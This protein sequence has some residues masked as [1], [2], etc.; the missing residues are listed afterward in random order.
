[1]LASKCSLRTKEDTRNAATT[2]L[3]FPATRPAPHPRKCA[4]LWPCD[5]PK[6]RHPQHEALSTDDL[7]PYANSTKPLLQRAGSLMRRSRTCPAP[8]DCSH[9]KVT[10]KGARGR[11]GPPGRAHYDL[12]SL[13]SVQASNPQLHVAPKREQHIIHA[14]FLAAP[15]HITPPHSIST[16]LLA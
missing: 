6:P 2:D 12:R 9:D 16:T 10:P 11:R 7:V 15:P 8:S 4:S 1:M 5:L 3:S 13:L 14:H